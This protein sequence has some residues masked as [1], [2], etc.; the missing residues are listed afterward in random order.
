[1]EIHREITPLRDND[2]FLVMDRKRYEFDFPVHF[3]PEFEINFIYNAQGAKR[4]VGDHIEEI[5]EYE[6]VLIGPNIHHGWVNYKNN[7]QQELHE[8]TIQFQRNLFDEQILHKNVMK[9]IKEMFKSANYGILFSQETSKRLF[10]KFKSLNVK[11]GF[12]NFL[13]FQSLLYDLAISRG[14][15]NLTNLSFD[16]QSDFYN[17]ERIEKTFHFVK[18]N[19]HNKIKIEEAASHVSMTVISFSRFIK[20][21]TGKTFTNYVNEHRLSDAT[22]SLIES[23]SSVTEICYSCGFTNISNFNRIFKKKQGCSPSEFRLNYKG[24][25]TIY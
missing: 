10:E 3:H 9:P 17:S 5:N 23:S 6:L 4:I 24:T 25:K 11:N 18:Q 14:Q 20:K 1:M 19:Y 8:I 21:R 13:N 2:S 7:K 16:K 22:K 12:D 15:T